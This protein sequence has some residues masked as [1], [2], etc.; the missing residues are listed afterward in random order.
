[1]LARHPDR[2]KMRDYLERLVE[3]FLPLSGDRLFGEDQAIL[4]GL[5]RFRNM[6]VLI[7][8]HSKG[9]TLE[10]NQ[11]SR[12]G[13]P[14][15]EGYRKAYR[16]MDLAHRFKLPI[17]SFIDTPGAYPGIE[18]EER[19]QASAIAACL[20]KSFELE[21]PIIAVVIGE[22]GSGGAIAIGVANKILMLEN[23]IYSVIS[24]EGCA[25]ILWK[26]KD[27]REE[28]AMSQKL[29][30]KDLLKLQVIDEVIPEPLGGAHRNRIAVI[31][32]VGDALERHLHSLQDKIGSALKKD[33]CDKF[34]HMTRFV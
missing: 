29:L 33:R 16:L 26:T 22:G 12:F 34:V 8:G 13:M 21:V 19:G 24:P 27:K 5:G 15:P 18:A 1:M 25:S 28:A 7:M 32:M 31:D 17:L 10:E 6:S 30:A 11:Q 14:Y 23:T 2:P 3:D 4:G 20:E 9:R